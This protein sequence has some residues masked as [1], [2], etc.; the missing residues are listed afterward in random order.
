MVSVVSV[1]LIGTV[2]LLQRRAAEQNLLPP[3]GLTTAVPSA[4]GGGFADSC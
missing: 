1:P 3:G 4:W 2:M